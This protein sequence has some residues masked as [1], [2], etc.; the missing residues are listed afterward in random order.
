LLRRLKWFSIYVG[1]TFTCGNNILD[2]N[3][4]ESEYFKG[5]NFVSFNLLMQHLNPQMLE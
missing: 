2:F 3:Q 4:F 5:Y 1:E